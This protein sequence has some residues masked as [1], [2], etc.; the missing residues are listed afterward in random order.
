M[1]AAV[2]RLVQRQP[3]RP[4]VARLEPV[5]TVGERPGDLVAAGALL[6]RD[7]GVRGTVDHPLGQPRAGQRLRS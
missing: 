2:M 4:V 3:P 7:L 5:G 1:A 6:A